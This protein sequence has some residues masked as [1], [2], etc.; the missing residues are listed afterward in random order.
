[1]K[2]ILPVAG[3]GERMRPYTNNLPKC[4]LPVGIF[5]IAAAF[6][7]CACSN[8]EYVNDNV[9][10]ADESAFD[11]RTIDKQDSSDKDTQEV[12]SNIK[13]YL[14]L[15]DTEYPY[16]GIPRIVIETENHR[17]IKDRETEIPAKMQI[18]GEKA[19]ESEIIDL[20]IRGRGN[21]SWF[22]MAKKSYK[23][24]LLDK[25]DLLGMPKDRD[26]AL[27]SNHADKTLM[28][29]YL[30]YTI[31]PTLGV[32]YAPRCKFADL[33]LNGEYLGVYLLTETIKTGKHR[34]NIPENNDS[35]IVEFDGK[36]REGE[37]VFFSN[38]IKENKPF[39]VHYPHN[40]SDSSLNAIKSHVEQ[41]EMFLKDDFLK[42]E[43]KIDDWIDLDE[44][45]LHY[46]LLELTKNPDATFFTSVYF[47][48]VKGAKIEMGPVW[49]LDVAF[50]NYQ[51]DEKNT[52][53]KWLIRH[54]YWNNFLF[55]SPY[56]KGPVYQSWHDNYDIF[57]S[58]L[59][60]IETQR[61]KLER[62]AQNNFKRWDVLQHLA[63]WE[64]AKAFNTYD[65]AVD[66][67]KIWLENRIDW[68]NENIP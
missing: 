36:Y 33:F 25:H 8:S 64:H 1:M 59:D 53:D 32:K 19:P 61:I 58:L 14:P 18:W 42:D 55:K 46:W 38:I 2:V 51:L 65:E 60:S 26:W 63:P 24:E 28:R 3:K 56:F 62:P 57:V 10:F 6:F 41:F 29:N 48:W 54:S 39:R 45:I 49:D 5:A 23:I 22:S 31:A 13:T 9:N 30:V 35:Y 43:K 16:A 27:I 47:Y 34:V 11:V 17:A 40:I 37:Q 67:L 68:I 12:S 4:L 21:S 20:T 50:G 44:Y 15:D 52:T 7:L 66:S